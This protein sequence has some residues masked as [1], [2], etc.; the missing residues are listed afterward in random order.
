[1]RYEAQRKRQRNEQLVAYVR[2]NPELSYAEV[3]EKYGITRSRV[4]AIL[5]RYGIRYRKDWRHISDNQAAPLRVYPKSNQ[6][7]SRM[8]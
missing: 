3:G 5:R 2:A 8:F 7:L 6:N 4:S 1:M